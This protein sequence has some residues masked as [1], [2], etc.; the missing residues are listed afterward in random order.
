MNGDPDRTYFDTDHTKPF[1]C[2]PIVRWVDEETRADMTKISKRVRGPFY[3]ELPRGA[4]DPLAPQASLI[5]QPKPKVVGGDLVEYDL[6]LA[7]VPQRPD[8]PMPYVMNY[9]IFVRASFAD[10]LQ[11]MELAIP[12]TAMVSWRYYNTTAPQ[13]IKLREAFRVVEIAGRFYGVGT[14]P[15]ATDAT[16]LAENETLTRKWEGGNIWEVK[17]INV[18]APGEAKAIT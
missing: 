16:W 10:P 9:Q 11:L 15:K 2:A 7:T 1:V 6:I 14:R 17:S 5:E 4:R 13:K 12:L 3:A 18:P 8:E